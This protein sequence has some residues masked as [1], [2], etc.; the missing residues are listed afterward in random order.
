MESADGIV[1]YWHGRGFPGSPPIRF[2][3]PVGVFVMDPGTGAVMVPVTGAFRLRIELR[4][5]KDSVARMFM[6]FSPFYRSRC[7]LSRS[8]THISHIRSVSTHAEGCEG[9][10]K[11]PNFRP[12]GQADLPPLS[13]QQ[14]KKKG[15]EDPPVPVVLS[16]W[17]MPGGVSRGRTDAT[18][19]WLSFYCTARS[20]QSRFITLHLAVTESWTTVFS[21]FSP[22]CIPASTREPGVMS[23]ASRLTSPYRARSSVRPQRL[24]HT[25]CRL[26]S[27]SRCGGS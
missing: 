19:R 25:P 7:F 11:K 15:S 17:K 9:N 3:I 16:G 20:N 10:G 27:S 26:L 6:D 23:P 12:M 14:D 22:A 21:V 24:S 18:R 5:P 2:I 13:W 8:A 1:D 4:D